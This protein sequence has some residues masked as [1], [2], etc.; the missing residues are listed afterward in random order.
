MEQVVS[1]MSQETYG[2]SSH[3]ASILCFGEGDW[4]NARIQLLGPEERQKNRS[5]ESWRITKSGLGII[6]DGKSSKPFGGSVS[7][8]TEEGFFED[9]I[10]C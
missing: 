2:P 6:W 9:S 1:L 7:V 4:V 10:R 8:P 3:A 5:G